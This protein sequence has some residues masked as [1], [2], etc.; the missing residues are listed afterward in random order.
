MQIMAMSSRLQTQTTADLRRWHAEKEE[1]EKQRTGLLRRIQHLERSNQTAANLSAADA[2]AWTSSDDMLREMESMDILRAD[3]D[4]LER[5]CQGME[6]V[7]RE[8]NDETGRLDDAMRAAVQISTRIR[9][10]VKQALSVTSPS[11][12]AS[13]EQDTSTPEEGHDMEDIT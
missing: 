9:S 1:W 4:R 2:D 6:T 8:L 7:V 3:I 13:R 12:G 11:G 10:K 5:T